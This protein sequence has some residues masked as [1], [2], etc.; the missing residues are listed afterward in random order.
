MTRRLSLLVLL[1]VVAGCLPGPR[2]SYVV[3]GDRVDALRDAFNAGAGTV[4][5]VMLVAPS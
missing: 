1:A 4:R 5:V 2:S 3:L